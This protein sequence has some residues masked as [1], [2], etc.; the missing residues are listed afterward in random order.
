MAVTRTHFP[1]RIDM[2]TANGESI[3]EH[4]AGV[5]DYQVAPPTTPPSPAIGHYP[6]AGS[7]LS[8]LRLSQVLPHDQWRSRLMDWAFAA[9]ANT[10]TT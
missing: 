9:E 2:W 10:V 1:F 6:S 7:G 3:V 5:E 4:V 8:I